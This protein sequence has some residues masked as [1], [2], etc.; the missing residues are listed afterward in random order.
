MER[1]QPPPIHT[2]PKRFGNGS[3]E[4]HSTC[5][6]CHGL[7]V[8]TFCISP[9]EGLAGFQIE[10]MKCLQCGNLFDHT[11]LEN[12]WRSEHQQLIHYK[13]ARKS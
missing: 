8:P 9:E 4:S 13:G 3:S 12:R 11:I 6:R 5:T 7:L 2:S 1:L 10:I